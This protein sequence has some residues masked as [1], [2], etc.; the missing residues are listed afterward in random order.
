MRIPQSVPCRKC[1][2][3]STGEGL[4][5]TFGGLVIPPHGDTG[6]HSSRIYVFIIL[7]SLT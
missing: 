2:S 4:K 5:G 3:N 6:L 1:F 7:H